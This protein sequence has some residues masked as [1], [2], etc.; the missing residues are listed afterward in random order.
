LRVLSGDAGRRA[1][2]ARARATLYELARRA[3]SL[4]VARIPNKLT[5]IAGVVQ[6]AEGGETR[7]LEPAR[8]ALAGLVAE[9]E[10]AAPTSPVTELLRRAWDV[11]RSLDAPDSL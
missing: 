6:R 3:E 10:A 11:V 1:S 5:A 4:G 9:H 7:T 8:A 2:F